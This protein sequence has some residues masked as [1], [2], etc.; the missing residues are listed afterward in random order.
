MPEGTSVDTLD[1][2]IFHQQ[3]RIFLPSKAPVRK[4]INTK[5]Q[6][7]YW[8]KV[9]LGFKTPKNAIFGNYID[10][11]CPFTGRVSIRGRILRGHIKRTKMH[12]TVV[13]RRNYLHFHKKYQR[14]EKR[15]RNWSVHMSPCFDYV[16]GDEVIFGECR[17]LSKT[18]RFNALQVNPKSTKQA[19]QMKE[20]AKF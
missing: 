7:R 6:K 14:F 1:D 8:K 19:Q 9:G 16:V 11:K 12:R 5:G 4:F 3:D 2:R 10:H 13:I 17:P 18:I 15:H 20:F